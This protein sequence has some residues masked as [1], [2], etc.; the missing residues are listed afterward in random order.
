MCTKNLAPRACCGFKSVQS[1]GKRYPAGPAASGVLPADADSTDYVGVANNVL[2][3]CRSH[4]QA[5]DLTPGRQIVGRSETIVRCH[6]DEWS[7]FR[8]SDPCRLDTQTHISPSY[9]Y[10]H[11]RARIRSRAE[12]LL[13][14]PDDRLH[15]VRCARTISS[16]NSPI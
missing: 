9:C 10:Q 4:A 12:C 13:S 5:R 3:D 1:V 11:L 16:V 15:T 7:A 8:R 2:S 6:L 14:S